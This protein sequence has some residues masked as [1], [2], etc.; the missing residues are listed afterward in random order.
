MSRILGC[1]RLRKASAGPF[2]EMSSSSGRAEA[3]FRQVLTEFLMNNPE[4]AGD[5]FLSIPV[6]KVF[7][8]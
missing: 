6:F 8:K 2:Q 3:I 1:R 4:P 7:A 5:I